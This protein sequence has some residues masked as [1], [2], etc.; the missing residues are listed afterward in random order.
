MKNWREGAGHLSLSLQECISKRVV[1][2]IVDV[3]VPEIL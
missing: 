2:Q 3:P 1:E